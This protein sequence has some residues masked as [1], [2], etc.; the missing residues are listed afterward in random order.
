MLEKEKKKSKINS[1]KI[2]FTDNSGYFF[3]VSK[4]QSDAV[5]EYFIKKQTLVNASRFITEELLQLQEETSNAQEELITLEY[6]IYLKL[7]A[8]GKKC[9]F[10]IGKN[11]R[12]YC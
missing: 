7:I 11:L 2:K 4:T 8:E 1:L 10:F 5:P 6:Q 9:L 12:S 3:E